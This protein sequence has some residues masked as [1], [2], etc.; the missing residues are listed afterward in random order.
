MIA[1]PI[2]WPDGARC[3]VAMTWDMDA[4]SAFNWYNQQTADNLVAAQWHPALSGRLAR[5]KAVLELLDYMRAK[6]GV[7][8]ARL[9]QVCDHVQGL[10]AEGRW[11]PR[12]ETFPIYQSPLPEFS[13]ER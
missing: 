2:P 8:F 12:Y 5:F 6:G 4:D 13:K 10:M 3:A 1:N 9:D 11:T 7:W